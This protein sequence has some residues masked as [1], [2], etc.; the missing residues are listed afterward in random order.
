MTGI[1]LQAG[2]GIIVHDLET[3][4]SDK[5]CWPFADVIVADNILEHI[6][7]H[8]RLLNDCHEALLP[9]GRMHIRVPNG[10]DPVT[11]WADPTHVR[12][13]VP[14]TFDYFDVAHQR[15]QEYGKGYGILP[16]RIVYRREVERFIDV[17][18]RPANG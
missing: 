17:M 12:A 7:N 8:I 2:E 10:K 11:A 14:D 5:G 9:A 13:W 18:M 3:G 4:L 6:N 15:W 16:W 1:D